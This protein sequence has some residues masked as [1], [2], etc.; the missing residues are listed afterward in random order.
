MTKQLWFGYNTERDINHMTKSRDHT[1]QI[2]WYMYIY[3]MNKIF[4]QI[5][6]S[7]QRV[8]KIVCDEDSLI[9]MKYNTLPSPVNAD[10]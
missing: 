9:E 1:V 5:K 7:L 2:T 3:H 6:S 10:F 8:F 4:I